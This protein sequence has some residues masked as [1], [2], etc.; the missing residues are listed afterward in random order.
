LNRREGRLHEY[1]SAALNRF[2]RDVL[3]PWPVLTEADLL[4]RGRGHPQAAAAFIEAL[5]SDVH[6]LHTPTYADLRLALTLGKRYG[7]LGADL[8]DLVVMA[9]ALNRDLPVFT[10]DFRHFRVVRDRD[11]SSIRL[12]VEEHE[13]P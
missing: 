5:L 8:P 6:Q 2:G 11:G 3:V 10:W 13:L 4:L 7:D 9:V 12:L 1:A